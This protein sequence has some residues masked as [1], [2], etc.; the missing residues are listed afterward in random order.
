MSCE[1]MVRIA[2]E[3]A[4]SL[5]PNTLVDEAQKLPQS[6]SKESLRIPARTSSPKNQ[7]RVHA[8]SVDKKAT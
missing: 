4:I 5:P 1:Q 8:A 2:F 6:L 3:R 7:K